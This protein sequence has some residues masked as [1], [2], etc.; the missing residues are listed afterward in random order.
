MKRTTALVSA[1]AFGLLTTSALASV[2]EVQVDR[3]GND[4]TPMGS[5][6][7][8]EK[9]SIGDIPEWTGG[10]ASVPGNVTYKPGDHLADPFGSDK[11]LFTVTSGNAGQY[12]DFLTDGQKGLL[13]TYGD[14]KMNVYQS[15]R[16]CALP[17]AVYQAN[18]NNAKVGELTGG[19]NG[20][21]KAILG[22][23]F[24]IPNNGLE[25]TWNHLLR[26]RSFKST[27]QFAAAALT[28]DG[29]YTLQIVQDDAIIK[30]ADPSKKSAEDLNNIS[31]FYL[32][33][34]I[35]PARSAGNVVLVY[36]SLNAQLQPRQAWQYSP[37]TRRVRRAPNIAYDNPGTNSDG[38]STSDAFDGYNGAP[39]RYDWE[40]LGKKPKVIAYNNYKSGLAHYK[41]LLT[42]LHA[43]QDLVRYELHRSWI[44]QATL[45]PDMRHVYARRVN[46]QDEDNWSVAA[47]ELYDGR[48]QLWRVQEI[49]AVQCYN[50]PSCGTGAEL[51]YDLQAGRYL[52]LT[53]QNEEPP[54]NYFAD[55]LNVSH[56]TPAAMRQLGVR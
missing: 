55:E 56:Y 48:G 34:T 9:T 13:K 3:I 16:T 30:W 38:L 22:S 5:E 26:Y 39:D 46:Y 27:R 42:P 50:V 47:T 45:K 32:A 40:V 49:Q 4:L 19:G 28:R 21:G 51:V 8:G 18:K 11:P 24:P 29:D 23:P 25:I 2:P 12:G 33:N 20:V 17:D 36:E 53:M 10:L 7:A 31:L 14:Y 44:V 35:A 43:N 1:L 41:D 15:R 37:G 52:A 6:K 54:A